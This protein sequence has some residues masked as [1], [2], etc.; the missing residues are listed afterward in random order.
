MTEYNN[1]ALLSQQVPPLVHTPQSLAHVRYV[2]QPVLIVG[3]SDKKYRF[4]VSFKVL[5]KQVGV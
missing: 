2:K 1:T 5:T 4:S 3:T